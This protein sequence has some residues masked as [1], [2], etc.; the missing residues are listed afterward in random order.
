VKGTRNQYTL[1]R[2]GV[3]EQGAEP[4]GEKEHRLEQ[5]GGLCDRQ[6]SVEEAEEDTAEGVA[7]IETD[8]CFSHMVVSRLITGETSR[9]RACQRGIARA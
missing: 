2:N 7:R 5:H 4:Y 6:I 3:A 9:M 8:P 1:P